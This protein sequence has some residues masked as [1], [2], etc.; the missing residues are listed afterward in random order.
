[1]RR[2]PSQKTATKRNA[3]PPPP[4][5]PESESPTEENKEQILSATS[6]SSPKIPKIQKAK[7]SALQ[8]YPLRLHPGAEIKSTL[9]KFVE[10]NELK[11]AFILSCVGSVKNCK[12][13]L[14]DSETVNLRCLV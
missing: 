8:C 14:A 4:P 11:S 13:R 2:S 3:S 6:A 7:A 5:P 1:M 10:G 12:L 9:K